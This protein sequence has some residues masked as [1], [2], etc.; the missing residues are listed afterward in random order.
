MLSLYYLSLF[1]FL[2][3]KKSVFFKKKIKANK[4]H[5]KKKSS[6]FLIQDGKPRKRTDVILSGSKGLKTVIFPW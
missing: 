4:G 2:D 6:T 1:S 3:L 5:A